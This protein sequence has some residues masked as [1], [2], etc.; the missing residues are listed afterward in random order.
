MIQGAREV[1]EYID[2]SAAYRI[3]HVSREVKL[4]IGLHAD[5]HQ[6]LFC[7]HTPFS[8]FDSDTVKREV[9]WEVVAVVRGGDTS[10]MPKRGSALAL[11]LFRCS[12]RASLCAK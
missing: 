10:K 7:R 4:D 12:H 2:C 9:L 11:N 3:F 1:H 5:L 8:L 6:I